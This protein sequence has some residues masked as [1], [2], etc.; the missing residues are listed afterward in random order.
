MR[1]GCSGAI[2]QIS[3]M[4]GLPILLY[5]FYHSDDGLGKLFLFILIYAAI[6]I[7]VLIWRLSADEYTKESVE[8]GMAKGWRLGGKCPKCL[9][10]LPHYFAT[11]CPYCT[12]D[13]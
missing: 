4:F 12:S 9:K 8:E 13:I 6:N 3:A 7:I 5:N 10:T 2:I 1:T 11:K